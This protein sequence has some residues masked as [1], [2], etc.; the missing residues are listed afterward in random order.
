MRHGSYPTLDI[1]TPEG[2]VFFLRLA[3]PVVRFLAWLVDQACILTL[4]Q[5]IN[6]LLGIF[7]LISADLYMAMAVLTYFAV[8]VSY[9]FLLEWFMN[10]QTL[11][12]R[13]LGLR[14]MDAQG[15]NLSFN[16]VVI[17]NLLRFVDA[18]PALYMLG[19]ISLFLSKKCQRLGDLA[20]NTI[21]VWSPDSRQPDFS[22]LFSGKFNSFRAY[23]HLC[24]RLLQTVHPA[25]ADVALNALL[26]RETLDPIARI[27]LF[28]TIAGHF[29]LRLVFP[30]EAT[31]GLS[32]E[33]YTR[34]L[35]EIL[36]G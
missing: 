6:K 5:V 34:N 7:G 2:L 4:A 22:Q 30:Q 28:K 14:V 17:R 8:S 21:V 1:H 27:S 12:K 9:G 35:V 33:Q 10:G 20:A 18:L 13:I 3:G 25:E 15:L 31:D 26:R 19:G 36:F 32:D 11:G 24:A 23:P 29:K 16:Q